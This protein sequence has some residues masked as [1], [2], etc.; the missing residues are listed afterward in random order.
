LTFKTGISQAVLRL[1]RN[2]YVEALDV[3]VEGH[4]EWDRL[5]RQMA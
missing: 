5:A 1:I 2:R 4:S 3:W